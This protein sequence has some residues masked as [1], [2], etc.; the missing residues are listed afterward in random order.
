[1]NDLLRAGMALIAGG[2]LG[3][4]FFVGLWLTVRRVGRSEWP[5]AWIAGSFLGRAAIALGGFY[6]I[7]RWGGVPLLFG[8]LGF[9]VPRFVLTRILR[10]RPRECGV[11][12]E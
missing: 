6:L 7:G 8:L 9:L 2:T 3:L 5:K 4:F 12:H 10:P 11:H 1:M